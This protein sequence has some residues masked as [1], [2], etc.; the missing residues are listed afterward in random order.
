MK[1][2]RTRRTESEWQALIAEQRASGETQVAWCLAH[3]VNLYT[4]RDRASRLKKQDKDSARTRSTPAPTI[5][6]AKVSWAEVKTESH[7][8]LAV[9]A[10]EALVIELQDIRIHVGAGYGVSKL[11]ALCRELTRPW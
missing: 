1:E 5:G 9:E 11:A 4:L 7:E 8:D 3:G 6:G 2:K 10:S